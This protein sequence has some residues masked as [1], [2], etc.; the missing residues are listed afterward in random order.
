MLFFSFISAM[1]GKSTA[2]FQRR[3]WKTTEKS[4][5]I[6]LIL[7]IEGWEG[8]A[9]EVEFDLPAAPPIPFYLWIQIWP[10]FNVGDQMKGF[11]FVVSPYS[12]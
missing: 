1:R 9:Q 11:F 10:I 2:R 8:D 6:S 7:E 5:Q 3:R 4:R 12:S